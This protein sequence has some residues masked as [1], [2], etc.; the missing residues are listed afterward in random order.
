MP[1]IYG[2][3]ESGKAYL[4]EDLGDTT[5]FQ[6]LGK[7]RT[8]DGFPPEVVSV[9]HDVV[10]WLPRMQIEAGRTID[11]RW[12]YLPRASFDKQSMLW[13]L[14]LL[15]ILLPDLGRGGVFHEE[16]LENDFQVFADYLLAADRNYFPVPRL[17][18]AQRD[19]EGR[20]AL[21][22]STTRAARRGALQ[23]DICVFALRR[24]G[25]RAV[26]PARRA[27]RH[28]H[29]AGGQ[30]RRDRQG[31]VQEILP[32][33]RPHPHHAGHGRLRP[34]RLP[35]EEAPLP[36]EHP[37]RDPQHRARAADL[38]APDRRSRADRGPQAP[39]RLLGAAPVRRGQAQ[40][41]GP[42]PELLLQ[43]RDA[44]RRQEP[45]RRIRVRLP[46]P[47]PIP[48]ARPSSARPPASTP[49]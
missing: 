26:R 36:A 9:Y 15:Q 13:D 6:F 41:D 32:G 38:A 37:L 44:A 11:D 17:P 30:A 16:R 4:E 33:V 22:Q 18:V 43:E 28:V 45:R 39:G 20:Q 35:R 31:R 3:H 5:L 23:Y 34:A 29:P 47:A 27:P 40:A 1:E 21:L 10:R 8:K 12:C 24:E 46:L 25:R 49:T 19:A 2:E 7:R 14:N 42:D 48:A